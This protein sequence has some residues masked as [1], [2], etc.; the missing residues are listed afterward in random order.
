V[1]KNE[2]VVHRIPIMSVGSSRVGTT[3]DAAHV[4]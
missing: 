2:T 3:S 1:T 4:G